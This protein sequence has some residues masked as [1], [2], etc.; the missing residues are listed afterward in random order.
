M[1]GHQTW[2]G[3]EVSGLKCFL[4]CSYSDYRAF[5]VSSSFHDPTEKT[6]GTVQVFSFRTKV[7]ECF[8]YVTSTEHGICSA[9]IRSQENEIAV[10][11]FE[12]GSSIKHTHFIPSLPG[13]NTAP[14]TSLT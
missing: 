6:L 14:H 4:L 8:L 1:F 7:T 5:N 3:H 12:A 9:K 13:P 2:A 10:V 11:V